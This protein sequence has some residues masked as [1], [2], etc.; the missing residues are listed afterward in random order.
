MNAKY[1]IIVYQ[2]IA[3]GSQPRFGAKRFLQH[4]AKLAFGTILMKATAFCFLYGVCTFQQ[5]AR[6]HLGILVYGRIV[7]KQD[8]KS[9]VDV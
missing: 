1:T 7:D 2:H 3:V 8:F 5:I 4:V 9:L 6:A